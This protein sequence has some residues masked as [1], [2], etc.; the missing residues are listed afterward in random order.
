M[1]FYH[2]CQSDF[3]IMNVAILWFGIYLI[4]FLYAVL[5]TVQLSIITNTFGSVC[6]NRSPFLVTKLISNSGH[7]VLFVQIPV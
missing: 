4:I 5:S 3:V 1:Y 6:R 2:L 7:C